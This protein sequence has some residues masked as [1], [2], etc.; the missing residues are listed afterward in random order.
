MPTSRPASPSQPCLGD[1]ARLAGEQGKERTIHVFSLG[2][3]FNNQIPLQPVE[4]SNTLLL[5]DFI[6]L[7]LH[8]SQWPFIIRMSVHTLVRNGS[9]GSDL[10]QTERHKS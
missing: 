10:Q 9:H 2:Y 3:T 6:H 1:F 7:I 4:Q 5:L 8:Q